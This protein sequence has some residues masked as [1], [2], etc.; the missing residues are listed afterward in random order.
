MF[1]ELQ[2]RWG[3][4]K[5]EGGGRVVVE[6]CAWWRERRGEGQQ[7]YRQVAGGRESS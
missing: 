7:E 3:R 5:V 6:G 1:N 4:G 2:H